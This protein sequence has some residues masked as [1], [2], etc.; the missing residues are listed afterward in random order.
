MGT[1]TLAAIGVLA[2]ALALSA[3]SAT[4]A[5]HRLRRRPLRPRARLD[6]I[7]DAAAR[8]ALDGCVAE[9]DALSALITEDFDAENTFAARH[10]GTAM[11][12]GEPFWVVGFP[13]RSGADMG[14]ERLYCVFARGAAQLVNADNTAV[15]DKWGVL[16]PS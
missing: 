11:S 6:A 8:A 14:G 10:D 12:N 7:A 13:S 5:P 3:C 4:S 2:C 16:C 1:A 15:W 9:L